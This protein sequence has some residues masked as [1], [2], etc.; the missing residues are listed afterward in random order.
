MA[1]LG[2]PG[3]K[4]AYLRLST[5]PVEQALAD[6]P[7]DPAA[8]EQRRRRVVAGAYPLRRGAGAPAA[9][10]VAMGAVVTEAVA[11]ASQLDALGYQCDVIVVTSPGLLF[12]AAQSRQGL[13]SEPQAPDWILD[14]AFPAGRAAP[15][16]T[17]LD[18]HPHTLAFLAGLNRVRGAHLGVSKFGQSGDL[19]SVYRWHGIDTSTIVGAA[20][21]LIE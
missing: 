13:G 18:G 17:V 1:Q 15:M 12:Q 14:D 3:G 5:R 8:R 20:L 10:I 2:R 9:T 6:V 11:A 21:D 16:V 7:A 19:D 4:S